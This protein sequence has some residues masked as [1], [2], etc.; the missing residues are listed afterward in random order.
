L[1]IYKS[2]QGW[3]EG[4]ARRVLAFHSGQTGDEVAAEDEPGGAGQYRCVCPPRTRYAVNCG[5]NQKTNPRPADPDR[6]GHSPLMT[7][8]ELLAP[9]PPVA[10]R[11]MAS[12]GVTPMP[13]GKPSGLPFHARF[14]DVAAHAGL[15]EPVIY[16]GIDRDLYIIEPMGSGIAFFDYDND[17]WLDIFML[18]G[19][20]PEGSP[21][22]ATNRLYQNNRDGTFTDVTAKA[23]LARTGWAYGVTIADYNN[24]GFDDNFITYWGQNVLYRNNGNGTF[25]DVTKEAGLLAPGVR[26]G[27]GCTFVDYDRDGH[28]DLFVSNYL[29]FDFKTVPPAGQIASCNWKGIP[30]NRSEE[31]TSELQSLRHL[32]CRLLLEKTEGVPPPLVARVVTP[33]R[34]CAGLGVVSGVGGPARRVG[35]LRVANR[36]RRA[37]VSFFFNDTATTEIYTLSLHDALPIC[38][39]GTAVLSRFTTWDYLSP[40]GTLGPISSGYSGYGQAFEIGRASCR[41]RV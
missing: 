38:L 14:T 35:E 4:R 21:P 20:R 13:R 22:G 15:R 2:P 5:E 9:I 26:W 18:S 12:R 23:G 41:E 1:P 6:P 30:V 27:S 8:R 31:H 32:V 10:F 36:V 37:L 24:D 34:Q 19:S 25:T 16:G 39:A 29:K 3:D 33:V 28:L 7:R 40:P 11:Q 17:G